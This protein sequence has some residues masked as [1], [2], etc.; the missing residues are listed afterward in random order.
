MKRTTHLLVLA[1]AMGALLSACGNG[2]GPT[3]TDAAKA[4]QAATSSTPVRAHTAQPQ[5]TPQAPGTPALEAAFVAEVMGQR[6]ALGLARAD[7]V[8]IG[9]T[10]CDAFRAKPGTVA[11]LVKNA[12]AA[13]QSADA[14]ETIRVV[15]VAAIHNLC[16]DQAGD[17]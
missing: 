7:L 9:H 8:T 15:A 2:N 13:G 3:P 16:A 17:L 10:T 12:T 11:T 1:V 4:P 6:P 14:V 5:A